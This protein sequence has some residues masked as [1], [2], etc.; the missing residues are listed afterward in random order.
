MSNTRALV[1]CTIL[2]L[3]DTCFVYPCCKCCL[4]RLIQESKRAICGK[5][6]F[7][8][9]LQNVDYRYRLSFK[10]SRKQDIFGV[11]VFGGCL[12][13]FFG[14]TAGG[15]QRCIDL[16][17]TEGTH[18]V[19]QLL[20]KAVEDC[21]IGRCVIFGLKVPHNV[22][23]SSLSGQLVACQI[24]S[25]CE[26]LMG[27]TVIGYFK[28]LLRANSHSSSSIGPSQQKHSQCSQRNELSFGYT[29][30]SCAKLDSQPSS[31]GFTLSSAWQSPGLCFP[32]EELSNDVLQQSRHC[33]RYIL[34]PKHEETKTCKCSSQSNISHLKQDELKN[35]TQNSHRKPFCLSCDMFE[36]PV[37]FNSSTAC[38]AVNPLSTL[39]CGNN[40]EMTKS[41]CLVRA[42]TWEEYDAPL[43]EKS[44]YSLDLEDAPLSESLHDFVSAEPQ[45]SE[46]NDTK[47]HTSG[48]SDHVI[49]I[50]NT[51]SLTENSS[52][53]SKTI[54]MTLY[55]KKMSSPMYVNNTSWK[56]NSENDYPENLETK[57]NNVEI[58]NTHTLLCDTNYSKKMTPFSPDITC[59]FNHSTNNRLSL[60]NKKVTLKRKKLTRSIPYVAFCSVN[61]ENGK[62]FRHCAQSEVHSVNC[63]V[64]QER[65]V[66]DDHEEKYNCSV[67]LF[68]SGQSSMDMDLSDVTEIC[69]GN[70]PR[71][72]NTS[73][74]GGSSSLLF[75]PCLQSTPVSYY[76]NS[77][78]QKSRRSQKRVDSL[79]SGKIKCEFKSKIIDLRLSDERPKVDQLPIVGSTES[80]SGEFDMQDASCNLSVNEWSKDLF[81]NSF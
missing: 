28:N 17:K 38:D 24:I 42:K 57:T 53:I 67:D 78:G 19:Q 75:L 77:C 43:H 41:E 55:S 1:S 63:K 79:C 45:I 7:T 54:P 62:C 25:P 48:K 81:E 71:H 80:F 12:N 36:S 15:L 23:T 10:V 65:I 35:E 30:P 69:K 58:R 5:C 33:D 44:L 21:F 50:Q 31:E 6:G 68:A 59:A 20:V 56:E 72:V 37:H 39:S 51:C 14:I 66:F 70:E 52:S 49:Q 60:S 16:E 3:Q 40:T 73:E 29:P 76:N 18:T 32:P 13:P 47:K 8:C 9:D 46:M 2:S 61:H 4:S 34:S 64:R 26:S 22:G 74:P 11:T 27:C